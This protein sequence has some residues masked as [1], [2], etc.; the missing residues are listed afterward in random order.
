V[1]PGVAVIASVLVAGC[2]GSSHS[3]AARRPVAQRVC[4]GVQKAVAPTLSATA[5]LR[6][7]DKDPTNIE[8]VVSDRKARIDVVAQATA[9]AWTEYDTTTV[10]QAQAYGAG[11]VHVAG[12]LPQYVTVSGGQ[13]AWIPAQNELVATNGTESSGGSYL[14]VKVTKSKLPSARKI[15]LA[16]VVAK[17]TLAL[18]PRGPSPGP[19]PS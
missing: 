10:H 2:G 6:I 9:V 11:S 18:A 7:V 8:C 17:T 13:A 3:S 12:Q 19:A 15:A 5:R 16:Q 14:T 1:A 4:A